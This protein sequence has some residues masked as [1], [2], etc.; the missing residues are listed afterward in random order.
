M[1]KMIPRGMSATADAYL[2]PVIQRYIGGFQGGFADKLKSSNASCHFMQSDGGLVDVRNFSGLRA[3]LSGPAGGV[4]GFARTS[5]DPE[6]GTPIIGFDMGGTST[7]VSRFD[8]AFEHTFENITAGINIMAPQLD[9][10]T[11]AAGGGSVL[12]WRHGLFVVGPDSAGAHP[13]PACYRK[14]GPLTISDANALT[15]RLLPEYFP[16]IFGESEQEPLDVDITRKKFSELAVRVNDE[17][18]QTK[19]PEE[20]AMGFINVAN[21]AMAKPI[22]ALTEA[23]GYDTSNH[24]LACFG[25]AGGQHACAIAASLAIRRVIIHRYSSILSAYGMA[26]ADV[27]HE[28]QMPASGVFL[29]AESVQDKIDML[30]DEVERELMT[31]GFTRHQISHEVYLNLR[32]R[33]TDNSLMVLKPADGDYLAEF[34]RQ[35]EREYSFI[36]PGRDVLLEDIRVR[37]TGHSA[38]TANESPHKELRGITK[39][40]VC[41]TDEA[42]RSDVYFTHYGWSKTPIYLLHNLKPGCVVPGPATIIDSTQTIIVEP[43]VTATI[44]SRHVILDL[45]SKRAQTLS[46]TTVDPISLSI[47]GHRFIS[48]AEQMGRMFAKT[49]VSVNIKERLDFS[50]AVFSPDG[51]LVANAPHVPV[52]LGSMEYAVRYQIEKWKDDLQPGDVICANH[53][54][55]GG[56]HL[57]DI[58]IITPVWSTDGTEVTFWVAS[59][60]HH[61]D[62]GGISPGSMPSNSQY[63]FEEGAATLGYKI[64]SGGRFDESS[65]RKFLFEEPSQYPRCSGSRNYSDNLSD[66]QAAIAANKKGAGLIDGMI[67]EYSLPVVHL[68]MRAIA[69]TAETAV[70]TFLRRTCEDRGGAP[71]AFVDFMDDGSQIALQVRIDQVSGDAIFD[72]TGT[73]EETLSC[74]N[75]PKAITYSAII[76]CLR[77]L[78]NTDIPLNQGCLAPVQVIIPERT[79]LNPSPGAA[80][81]LGNSTTSQRITDVILGAFRAAAASQGDV[82]CFGFGTGGKDPV[83]GEVVPG[84]GYLESI[85]G[86]SG[87]GPGWHGTSG[88][89]VHMSNTRCADPEVFELRY[90]VILRQWTL[91]KGSGGRGQFRGGEGCVRDVEFRIPLSVSMSSERRVF[92]PY[93]MAGGEPGGVGRNLYVKKEADGLERIIGIG[94]RMELKVSPGDRL[95]INTPGGGGWGPPSALE[96][97]IANS[98]AGPEG[99]T[100]EPR[101]SVHNWNITAEGV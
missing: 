86:G 80:V 1:I 73:S 9:I 83:T 20:I 23:K 79:L 34:V 35:H 75:A 5:Y 48:I 24:Y 101:G 57:P 19:T 28:A 18:G 16:K 2:T 76:Y 84:F 96:G 51:R 82:N 85:A 39:H 25:G 44:L 77:C 43:L 68:Y 52:H 60:G 12:S 66:L 56:T 6:D 64:V 81:C 37:G 27:T 89:H 46:M 58:T 30:R 71:L 45:P 62:I 21:E 59:R 17:T 31:D 47:F 22:R 33:G 94:S 88:V 67:Q 65:T 74:L 4:V 72:F 29:K 49:A 7:D 100:F 69:Q 32:Y 55:G 93:G 42:G 13:G 38:E 98:T 90:P 54:M 36:F 78:I 14:G 70:R 63:L 3:V 11:V 40:D 92:R 61:S 10:N 41:A 95:I 26:L 91:R 99:N 15:G 87:A 50:C 8:G 53:P 97:V